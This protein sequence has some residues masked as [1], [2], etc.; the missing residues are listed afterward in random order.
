MY[1]SVVGRISELSMLRTVGFGRRAII[2]TLVQ[3]G[4]LLAASASLLAAFLALTVING[5]AVRFTMGAFA[6]RVDTTAILIGCA[7]GLTLGV[8][9]AI[10]P[11][12]KAL[13]IPVVDGLK[14]L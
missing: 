7:V 2:A 12:I 11:A 13:R 4:I 3:E 14:A 10:P 8:V 9:G 5:A 6:L 1:G